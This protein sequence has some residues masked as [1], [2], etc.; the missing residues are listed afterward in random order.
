MIALLTHPLVA[1]PSTGDWMADRLAEARG[2]LADTTQHTDTL[3]ILAARVVI[4]QTDDARERSDALDLIRLL[5]HRPLHVVAAAA[6]PK[7]GTA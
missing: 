7:G 6:F 4:G 3:V 5:D 2:V 1:A